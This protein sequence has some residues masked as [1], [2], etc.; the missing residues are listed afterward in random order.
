MS[1]LLKYKGQ[2]ETKPFYILMSPN[3]YDSISESHFV[4]YYS[5]N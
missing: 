4:F 1:Y 5:S 2:K 3:E